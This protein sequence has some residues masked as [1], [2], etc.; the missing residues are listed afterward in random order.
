MRREMEGAEV[1][2]VAEKDERKGRPKTVMG[3]LARRRSGGWVG[4]VVVVVGVVWFFWWSWS[5]RESFIFSGWW[6]F[7]GDFQDI[8]EILGGIG[9][10]VFSHSGRDGVRERRLA[11]HS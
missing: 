10:S 3:I 7:G 4:V 8:T 1:W 5:F 9:I 11:T 2:S 6:D